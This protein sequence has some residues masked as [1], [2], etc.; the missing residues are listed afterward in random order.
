MQKEES[1]I[2]ILHAKELELKLTSK[3]V[4]LYTTLQTLLTVTKF[5]VFQETISSPPKEDWLGRKNYFIFQVNHD[6]LH[7]TKSEIETNFITLVHF[8][9]KNHLL[10][11]KGSTQL[12]IGIEN[13]N[14]DRIFFIIQRLLI[15]LDEKNLHRLSEYEDN[16]IAHKCVSIFRSTEVIVANQNIQSHTPF[17][18]LGI[19][20]DISSYKEQAEI[21][22][23]PYLSIAPDFLFEGY[24]REEFLQT[25]QKEPWDIFEFSE[26]KN[27]DFISL[28]NIQGGKYN[29]LHLEICLINGEK[30]TNLK[31][32]R[33]IIDPEEEEKKRA[34]Q[35]ELE[36]KNTIQDYNNALKYLYQEY[37]C[38]TLSKK[39]RGWADD[40]Y[41]FILRKE[42]LYC[43]IRETYDDSSCAGLNFSIYSTKWYPSIEK[44]WYHMKSNWKASIL[45]G[46]YKET[47]RKNKIEMNVISSH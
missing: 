6:D 29:D 11:R 1:N 44:L 46:W 23:A 27:I 42:N 25:Y 40:S 43:Y 13:E 16:K 30:I 36:K 38:S 9:K 2:S 41:S 17:L 19:Y 32:R 4:F 37:E 45:K 47:Q 35:R 18:P 5:H 33:Y 14:G 10:G 26:E 21:P 28:K 8:E 24:N 22:R 3:I 7:L 12:N 20:V 39:S 15:K 31:E 34:E